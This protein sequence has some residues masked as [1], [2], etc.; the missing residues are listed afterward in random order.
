MKGRFMSSGFL[1]LTWNDASMRRRSKIPT[2]VLGAY[3]EVWRSGRK[4]KMAGHRLTK[5]QQLQGVQ[6]ALRSK[7]TP[8]WLKPSMK[9]FAAQLRA[10]IGKKKQRN[11]A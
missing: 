1:P 2:K 5:N 4:E 6:K 7:R 3:F 9:E 11:Q 10:E 8:P